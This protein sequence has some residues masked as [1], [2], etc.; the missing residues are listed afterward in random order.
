MAGGQIGAP[1]SAWRSKREGA[2]GSRLELVSGHDTR[3]HQQRRQTGQ[4]ALVIACGH[5]VARRHA[6]D[7]VSVGIHGEE[8]KAH[9]MTIERI[10]PALPILMKHRRIRLVAHRPKALASA[11]IVQAIHDL[12]SRQARHAD[13]GFFGD[14]L[15]QLLLRPAQGFRRLDRDD[16]VAGVGGGIPYLDLG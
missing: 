5:I 14:N 10:D 3:F 2:A 12:G 8:P 15:N 1:R 9:G 11:H 13:H 16:H 4:G 7:G 6:L